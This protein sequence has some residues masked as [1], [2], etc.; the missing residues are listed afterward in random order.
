MRRLQLF[1]AVL[2]VAVAI[3][4]SGAGGRELLDAYKEM[5]QTAQNFSLPC[6]DCL[7]ITTALLDDLRAAYPHRQQVP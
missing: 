5:Q 7:T 1:A 4:S 3:G 6:G 2:L